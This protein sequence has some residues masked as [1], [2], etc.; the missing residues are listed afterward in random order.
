LYI[1]VFM[2]FKAFTNTEPRIT[3]LTFCLHSIWYPLCRTG[4]TNHF[5]GMN[6][7]IIAEV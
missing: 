2:H 7:S 3:F 5:G 6:W 1:F 4:A